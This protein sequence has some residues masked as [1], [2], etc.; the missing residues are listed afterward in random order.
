MTFTIVILRESFRGSRS[1]IR[2]DS[3][4]LSEKYF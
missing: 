3:G 1:A 4:F 2:N